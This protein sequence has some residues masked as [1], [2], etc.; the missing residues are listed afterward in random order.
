MFTQTGSV[1]ASTVGVW[2]HNPFLTVETSVVEQ[3]QDE[4]G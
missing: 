1:V 3:R 4:A 2:K